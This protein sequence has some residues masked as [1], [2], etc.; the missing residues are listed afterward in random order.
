MALV[1]GGVGRTDGVEELSHRERGVEVVV[2]GRDDT[3]IEL[4]RLVLQLQEK[5]PIALER[6]GRPA[7]LTA[8]GNEFR[9]P[10]RHGE[11]RHCALHSHYHC[12]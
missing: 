11:P 5:R 6:S 9:W 12:S 10:L 4:Q 7:L 2:H 1:R 8:S 3:F